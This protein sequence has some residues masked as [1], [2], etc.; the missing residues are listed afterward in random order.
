MPLRRLARTAQWRAAPG[1]AR[2][3][4]QPAHRPSSLVARVARPLLEQ[5]ER[6]LGLVEREQD[7]SEPGLVSA[8]EGWSAHL[9]ALDR[10][11]ALEVLAGVDIVALEPLNLGEVVEVE[12]DRRVIGS[13]V[14][15]ADL[16]GLA[17]V[18][19]GLGVVRLG[20]DRVVPAR[21]ADPVRSGCC[22]CCCATRPCTDDRGRAWPRR[23]PAPGGPSARPCFV[24]AQSRERVGD[25]GHRDRDLGVVR[26]E[27]GL[28]DRERA[29][30]VLA[31]GSRCRHGPARAI[32]SVG[33]S[34][35]R[36]TAR[37]RVDPA[38]RERLRPAPRPRRDR[39]RGSETRMSWV[40]ASTRV[41]SSPATSARRSDSRRCCLA[42]GIL[43]RLVWRSPSNSWRPALAVRRPDLFG[44][45]ER[46]GRD[47]EALVVLAQRLATVGA[48][49]QPL[50][51]VEPL[52][53]DVLDQRALV[54]AASDLRRGCWPRPRPG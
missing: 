20:R 41:A 51:L 13:E 1:P 42:S 38:P 16:D 18:L 11:R 39:A 19:L 3:R 27:L 33:R 35:P 8:T 26:S 2:T 48:S 7:A 37:R 6:G 10:E 32:R 22:R 14:G 36:S 15:G 45:R 54:R 47:L 31:R 17:V 12:R 4:S 21:C 44:E 52:V 49:Q 9:L 25:V 46:L 23:S 24:L 50:E 40:S 30:V 29:A 43:R 53:V 34:R 5:R 28:T